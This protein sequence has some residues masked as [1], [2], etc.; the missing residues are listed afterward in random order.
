MKDGAQLSSCI[1]PALMDFFASLQ[2]GLIWF[3]YQSELSCA[4]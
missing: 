2:H 1:N 3:L 4:S